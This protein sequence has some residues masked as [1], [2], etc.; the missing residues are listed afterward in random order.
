M[1]PISRFHSA[2]YVYW[3]FIHSSLVFIWSQRSQ[4]QRS[5]DRCDHISCD[6]RDHMETTLA[7]VAIIWKPLLRSLRSY[8]N[9]ALVT[10]VQ[11]YIDV[12][13]FR[14]IKVEFTTELIWGWGTGMSEPPAFHIF[15]FYS[16]HPPLCAFRLRKFPP[17]LPVP[18]TLGSRRLP[19]P[20]IS[21]PLCPSMQHNP[22]V[23]YRQTRTLIGYADTL[24]Q[25]ETKP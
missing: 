17:S 14:S 10:A 20:F 8:G 16:R 9:Q 1:S 25:V 19:T 2:I 6:R 12:Y 18:A 22:V 3:H 5:S 4:S 15:S 7:I 21:V 11:S 24:V 23:A 13:S